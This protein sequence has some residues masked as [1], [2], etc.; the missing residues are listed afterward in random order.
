MG[1]VTTDG[2]GFTFS[3]ESDDL[4]AWQGDKVRVLS[5]REPM[6]LTFALMQTNGDTLLLAMGGGTIAAGAGV[7]SSTRQSREKRR[8]CARHRLRG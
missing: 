3:R 6:S 5:S 7:F 8:A 4:D 1:Y 2:V